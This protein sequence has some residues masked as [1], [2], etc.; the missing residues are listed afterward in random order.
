MDRKPKTRPG[1]MSR[2]YSSNFIQKRIFF[3]RGLKVM[4]DDDLAVLYDVPTYRLNEQVKRNLRRF[5]KDFM[6]QL[7][8]REFENLISQF[9]IS[10]WGGRRS[11]PYAF[12][13]QGIAMLSS[14]LHSQRAIDVNIR[15]MRVFVRLKEFMLTHKD[16]ARKI[17]KLERK[18]K[19]H[20]EKFVVVFDAIRQ[21]LEPPHEEAKPRIGFHP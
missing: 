18:F 20:D 4:L 2:G 19:D 16:L 6:F 17:E 15:I 9:A 11:L 1:I 5:P 13:E 14:V 12:T 3:I 7:T 8:N 10:S 21:L